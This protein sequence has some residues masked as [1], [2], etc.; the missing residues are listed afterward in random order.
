MSSLRIRHVRRYSTCFQSLTSILA[1]TT[2]HLKCSPRAG[3]K[4]LCRLYLYILYIPIC[5]C[6]DCAGVFAYICTYTCVCDDKGCQLG[7]M[8]VLDEGKGKMIYLCFNEKPIVKTELE[9]SEQMEKSNK[10]SLA[11]TLRC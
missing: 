4:G 2:T 11:V 3:D 10:Q 7:D 5:V 8:E 6:D 9:K 1:Q